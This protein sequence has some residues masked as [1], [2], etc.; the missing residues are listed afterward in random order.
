VGSILSVE[1]SSSLLVFSTVYL[2]KIVSGMAKHFVIDIVTVDF[3]NL[4]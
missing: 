1:I 4:N 2:K 3:K